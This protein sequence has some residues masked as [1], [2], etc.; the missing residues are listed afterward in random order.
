MK[1]TTEFE[2]YIRDI[3]A[4]ADQAGSFQAVQ[5][6]LQTQKQTAGGRR[7]WVGLIAAAACVAVLVAGLGGSR[8]W[9]WFGTPPL[10][11][12]PGASDSSIT[13]EDGRVVVPAVSSRPVIG[14]YRTHL[15]SDE[16]TGNQVPD[17]APPRLE[18]YPENISDQ[19]VR[20]LDEMEDDQPMRV[21]FIFYD[22]DTMEQTTLE[23]YTLLT[24]E[25]E[26][27]ER[28]PSHYAER[29]PN[30][31]RVN[32][33]NHN[34]TLATLRACLAEEPWFDSIRVEMLALLEEAVAL[35]GQEGYD[36]ALTVCRKMSQA[37]DDWWQQRLYRLGDIEY[38]LV[39]RLSEALYQTLVRDY[40][41]PGLSHSHF[42]YD[43]CGEMTATLTKQQ[44]LELAAAD[45][46]FYF[47]DIGLYERPAGYADAISDQLALQLDQAPE[48]V[49]RVRI[50]TTALEGDWPEEWLRGDMDAPVLTCAG[51]TFTS[52]QI[53]PIDLTWFFYK[54]FARQDGECIRLNNA[55][56]HN[57]FLKELESNWHRK[58]EF[59]SY[60]DMFVSNMNRAYLTLGNG[61]VELTR[62]QLLSLAQQEEIL[63]IELLPPGYGML[64]SY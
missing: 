53:E 1:N 56:V 21:Q 17:P 24:L 62:E 13:S 35:G 54:R 45:D 40:S 29:C 42:K 60:G 30:W 61:M 6:R 14:V 8:L 2:Q 55:V 51:I 52:K 4:L 19:L 59:A 7:K 38:E 3:N 49:C 58:G 34:N 15:E 50:F 12:G 57:G 33:L 41:L 32:Q 44:I 18:G 9:G 31:M 25:C 20:K 22:R 16:L 48:E 5:E 27:S 36:L 46:R 28:Q 11:P 43:R 10:E 37:W 63:Y 26:L 64:V 23:G 47:E 39:S